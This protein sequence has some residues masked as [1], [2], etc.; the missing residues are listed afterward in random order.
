MP[1]GTAYES[2]GV[3]SSITNFSI[4]DII[5]SAL[6]SSAIFFSVLFCDVMYCSVLY[7]SVM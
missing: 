1:F 3:L 7:C 4:P 6:R 2:Q 5:G